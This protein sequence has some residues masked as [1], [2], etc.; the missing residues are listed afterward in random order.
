[1][2]TTISN[3]YIADIKSASQDSQA[4]AGWNGPG[5]YLI[6]NNYLE[7]SGENIMFGGADPYVPDLTP[8]DITIRRNTI[9][10][11][12]AWKSQSWQVK[13]LLELKNARDVVI[14]GNLFERHW[15]GAQSGY[16]ILFTP[17]NQD[18]RCP[19]CQVSNV[20]FE[21]NIIRDVSAG[22][23]ILGR[24][25]NAPTGQ[26]KNIVIA[27]NL[28]DGLD[29]K[30]WGGDGYFMQMLDDPRDITVDHNTVIQ[31]QSGGIA[32][33]DGTVEGFRFTNNIIGL[34]AYGVIATSRA[35]GNN[36]IR[37]AL[38]GSTISANVIAD[39]DE[40]LYPPGNYFPSIDELRRQFM[41]P[42]S[43]DYRLK[44]GAP[45]A[46]SPLDGLSLGAS[47]EASP[48]DS[49]GKAVP[50]DGSSGGADGRRN[51]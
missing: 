13:N 48:G 29:S 4:I 10:K 32:K 33:I 27:N 38:P 34:G 17:R 19:W 8:S 22:F 45:W 24:D 50:R 25:Y 18:G 15:A 23:S 3:S 5:P 47:L 7:A 37:A 39:G 44:P 11:P 51:R 6:E 1:V 26:T 40:G 42:Q 16:S 35:P 41:D 20:R 31:G 21:Q 12:L 46:K 2:S 28:F 9:A 43:R 30:Q 14:A 49:A 36:S